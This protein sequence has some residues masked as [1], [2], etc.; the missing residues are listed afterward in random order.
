MGQLNA[1]AAKPQDLELVARELLT[2]F[3]DKRLFMLY[4]EMGVGKTTF[5]K[6]ICRQ[7]GVKERISSPT[8]SIINEYKSDVGDRIFHFDFYRIKKVEEVF[9]L[10]YEDYFYSGNYCFIE[11][12][13]KLA[14]LKPDDCVEV[15]MQD[16][17]GVRSI[18]V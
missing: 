18:S 17:D 12:P 6:A 3:P 16:N 7:L 8:F 5:V 2:Q 15:F 13:E 11:W 1:T 9:D 14:S 10:G 4:G